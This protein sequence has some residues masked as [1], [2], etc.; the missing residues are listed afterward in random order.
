MKRKAYV[1]LLAAEAVACV[2]FA[3]LKASLAGVF[4]VAIAFPFEQIGLGLRALSLSGAPGN[5]AAIAIYALISLSPAALLFA[6]GKRRKLFAEDALLGLLSAALFA[7]LYLTVNPG[8]IGGFAGGDGGKAVGMAVLGTIAYSVICAYFVLRALRLFSESDAAALARNMSAMLGVLGMVFVFSAF[9]PCLGDLLG[10][11]AGLRAGNAGNEHLLGP[12]YAFLVLQCITD[13]LPYILN[14]PIVLAAL[15]L[16]GEYRADPY[17]AE[18]VAASHRMS[19]LC[20]AALAAT[21]LAN[22]CFNILQL[23]FIKSL[24]VV[25]V[26]L[27]IP[28][29]SIAF[30]LAALLLTRFAAGNKQLKDENDAFI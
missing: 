19:R 12:T 1:C 17:S 25:N 8:L 30:V 6:L 26:S 9:G 28:V 16:A 2:A 27:N 3:A 23:A 4:T 18:T 13:M 20:T 29:L 14:V 22:M 11:I 5:V 10:A 21:V 24:M 7:V 15:R